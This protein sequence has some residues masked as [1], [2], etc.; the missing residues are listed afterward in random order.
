MDVMQIIQIA[1]WAVTFLIGVITSVVG[2]VKAAKAK[3]D[4]KTAQE[5]E[6]AQQQMID[7]ANRLIESAETFYKSLDSV[8]RKTDGTTAG[9]YKKESVM[10][11]LAIF[12]Q[13]LGIKFDTEYWSAKIDEIVKMTKTVNNNSTSKQ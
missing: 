6:A 11:K 13:S 7:E 2:F 8:L 1:G 5:S 12:A 3:K 4:A 10:S 9:I